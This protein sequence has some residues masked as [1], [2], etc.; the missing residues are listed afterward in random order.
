MKKN[1]LHNKPPLIIIIPSLLTMATLAQHGLAPLY[2]EGNH[3]DAA[4]AVVMGAV[5]A[6]H[7]PLG[8]LLAVVALPPL[9]ALFSTF[10]LH[11]AVMM[12]V[13]ID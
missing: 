10:I 2:G 3:V 5:T 13:L 6:L 8:L 11:D 7:R 12:G 1:D 4:A 9:P